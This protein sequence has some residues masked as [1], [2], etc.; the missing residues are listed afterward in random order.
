MWLFTQY[1]FFSAVCARDSKTAKGFDLDRIVVRARKRSHLEAL[2]KRFRAELGSAPIQVG[3]GT[4]YPFRL[5]VVKK[6]W[7]SVAEALALETDYH[8]FKDAVAARNA[9]GPYQDA[10]HL[11]WEVMAEFEQGDT[12]SASAIGID[13]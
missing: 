9:A 8:N 2:R 13:D 12:R 4:V 11:V 3:G 5:F 10:L 1:G 7:A 6:T